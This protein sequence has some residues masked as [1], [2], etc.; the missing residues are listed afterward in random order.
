M[1][2]ERI[3]TGKP[4]PSREDILKKFNRCTITEDAADVDENYYF[5]WS[6]AL[7]A[8]RLAQ[9]YALNDLYEEI[10]HGDDEHQ[11]WL[12]EKIETFKSNLLDRHK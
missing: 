11:R 12:K 9:E 8:L 4:T 2:T 10:K 1:T 3:N 5:K 7:K 6:D